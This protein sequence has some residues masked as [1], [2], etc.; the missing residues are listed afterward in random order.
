MIGREPVIAQKFIPAVSSGDKRILLVDGEPIGAINRI[1]RRGS[2]AFESGQGRPG[3]GRVP[4]G[5]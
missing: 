1:P 3:R 4:Y 5:A 2:G